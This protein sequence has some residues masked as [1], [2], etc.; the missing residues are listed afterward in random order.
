MRR[1]LSALLLVALAFL[2][3][4]GYGRWYAKDPVIVAAK[5]TRR[6]LYYRCP[7]HPDFQSNKPGIAT[8][9]N[10]KLQPVYADDPSIAEERRSD[11]P[12]GTLRLSSQQQQLIGVEYGKVEYGPV[13]RLVRGV[14]RVIPNENRVVRVQTKLEGWVDQIHVNAVGTVVKKGQILLTIYN[15]KSLLAQQDF[16][17]VM[18]ASGV[19]M[20]TPEYIRARAL[21]QPVKGE[22]VMTAA[23]VQLQ[24]LGFTDAQI[25]GIGKVH[26]PMV[27]LPVTAPTS[28]TVIEY[29]VRPRQKVTP[30]T[31][32]TIANLSDIWVIADFYSVDETA[33]SPGQ[34]AMLSVPY[35]PGRSFT[36]TVDAVL[37]SVD[38]VTRSLKVRL[39][40]DNSDE[41]LRP[42]MCGEIELRIGMARRRL[43]VPREAVLDSGRRQVVFVDLGNGYVE[44]REVKTG[45]TFG[46]RLEIA[47]GL[48][49][50]E[51][52]VTSGAFLLDSETRNAPAQSV[53]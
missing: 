34:A 17:N 7:M 9:C 13:A 8:C 36:G 6:I 28:G 47:R 12:A 20:L 51:R 33:I 15:P 45:E 1:S 24:L 5:N 50:G 53:R 37:P 43:T 26:Q 21:N 39:L 52:I 49:P 29:N 48:K 31:L 35:L 44:P 22:G 32:Y 19:D 30:D 27:K 46:D 40:F 38:P 3:G 16:L 25:E 10:M 41:L 23:R 14:A 4:Y 42:E 11:L 18:E 2:G